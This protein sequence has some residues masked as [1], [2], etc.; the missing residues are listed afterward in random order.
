MARKTKPVLVL[1]SA[2][3]ISGLL[4]MS[5]AAGEQGK[6]EKE[7]EQVVQWSELPAVVQKVVKAELAGIEPQK[8]E[9]EV[10]AGAVAYEVKFERSGAVQ[11]IKVGQDGAIFEREQKIAPADLPALIRAQ[12]QRRHPKAKISK[13]ER[14]E[15]TLYEVKL[16]QGGKKRTIKVL[17]NGLPL[18]ED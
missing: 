7:K 17:P 9:R 8:I 10:R 1:W 5:A 4:A 13:A 15:L 11:E 2:L 6:N 18:D 3:A 16:E 14:V 12:I